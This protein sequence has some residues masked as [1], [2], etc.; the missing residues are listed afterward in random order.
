MAAIFVSDSLTARHARSIATDEAKP[1]SPGPGLIE[2]ERCRGVDY[3]AAQLIPCIALCE[4]VLSQAF[5]KIAPVGFLDSFENQIDHRPIVR[6]A[7]RS[8][9]GKQI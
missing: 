2:E 1:H 5:R 4:Y 7:G 6:T 9:P 3:I 8:R